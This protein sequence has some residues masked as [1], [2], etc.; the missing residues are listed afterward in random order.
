MCVLVGLHDL[1]KFFFAFMVKTKPLIQP[2]F[3]H[4]Q[5]ESSMPLKEEE[6]LFT[7]GWSQLGDLVVDLHK[8]KW[9]KVDL[10][11]MNQD[12]EY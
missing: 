8:V 6:Y 9:E 11:Y 7:F 2:M 1:L 10:I 3:T 4:F 5:R 12:R